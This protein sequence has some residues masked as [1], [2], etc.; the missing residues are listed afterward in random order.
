[1]TEAVRIQMPQEDGDDSTGND[2]LLTEDF[3]PEEGKRLFD[4]AARRYMDLSGEEFLRRWDAGEWKDDPD[5][6]PVMRLV[7]LL[8]FAGR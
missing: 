5:H 3:T 7:M 2:D 1:M 8:P 6:Y 4:E